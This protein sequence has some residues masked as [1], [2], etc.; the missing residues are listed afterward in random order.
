MTSRAVRIVCIARILLLAAAL[1]ALAACLFDQPQEEVDLSL[2]HVPEGTQS[3]RI[4]AVEKADNSKI[5]AP[6]HS[7]AW[8]GKPIHFALGKAQGK[9]CLLRVE[10]YQ[11]GYLVYLSLIPSAQPSAEAVAYPNVDAA[12]PGVVI[13]T[14]ARESSQIDIGTVFRNAPAGAKWILAPN[15]P[16]KGGAPRPGEKTLTSNSGV[17]HLG[18]VGLVPGTYIITTIADSAG[19]PLS[20]QLPDTLLTDE[21]LSPAGSSVTIVDATRKGDKVQIALAY[22]KFAMALTDEPAPGR[23]FLMAHDARGLRP[24]PGF[25][26]KGSSFDTLIGPAS[27]LAGVTTLVVALHY[28]DSVRVRPLAS[29]SVPVATALLDRDSL[30]WFQIR[31]SAKNGNLL[32]VIMDSKNR[33][34]D[35][36][37]HIFRNDLSASVYQRCHSDTCDVEQSIW[38]GAQRLVIAL[39]N[40]DHTLFVPQVKDTLDGPF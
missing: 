8:T 2:S 33:I 6:L 15:S 4:V 10:G 24:L 11:D 13:E 14:V 5:I 22:G 39:F 17:F 20:V 1:L 9:E 7:Q 37:Y 25:K 12:W 21:A 36:H 35:R 28:S 29:A 34:G 19:K 16:A 18:T 38:N 32:R 30:P 26:M 27:E 3:I 23:G 31:S 40:A